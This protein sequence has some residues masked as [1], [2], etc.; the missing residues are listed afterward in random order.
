MTEETGKDTGATEA[1]TD[2]GATDSAAVDQTPP[3]SDPNQAETK[4]K[5]GKKAGDKPGETPPKTDPS[6]PKSVRVICEGVLGPQLLVKGD[7]TADADYV[8]ILEQKGQTKVELV[9]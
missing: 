9:K 8:A 5:A 3:A 6:K 1:Q 4:G 2:K 7:V